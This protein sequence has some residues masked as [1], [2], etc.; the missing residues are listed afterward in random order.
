MSKVKRTYGRHFMSDP[1]DKR[2]CI[3]RVSSEKTSKYW[4][5]SWWRGNQGSQ[6][7]CVGYAWSH[8][9]ACSPIRQ[10]LNPDGIY[11][12]AQYLDQWDG[13]N[14]DGTSVRAGAKLL[15]QLGM[16]SEYKWA[17]DINNIISCI[18]EIG[19]VV[20]GTNWYEGMSEP[21]EKVCIHTTG[22]VLGGHAYVIRGV[23]TKKQRFQI[24]NSWGSDWGRNGRAWL[25]FNDLSVLLAENGEICL[26]I[27][28]KPK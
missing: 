19:P 14:Y 24:L 9:L 5:D 11:K 7:S 23:N 12:N 15:Q 8:W 6:P 20:V 3:Q 1:R 21:D 25:S 26:A 22:K 28:K 18:L 17:W 2:F 16:I 27:E 13:T 4:N 10:L